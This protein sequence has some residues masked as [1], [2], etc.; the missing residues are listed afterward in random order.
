LTY[1][2][3]VEIARPPEEVFRYLIE[4]PRQAHWSDVPMRQLT[5]GE[6]GSGSRMEVVFGMG[7]IKARIGLEL[8]D[9]D[10]PH[11]MA[12]RSFSG[13]IGWDGEY[14]LTPTPAGTRLSQTGQ[15]EFRGLWRLL[16]PLAGAE[17]SRGE[18]KELERLK[19]VAEQG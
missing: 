2:S 9:V 12:F 1:A 15:L 10:G 11:R 19:V 4:P 5:D 6:L 3:E 14:L 18:V 16:E 17:I 8:T 13:P 7:P